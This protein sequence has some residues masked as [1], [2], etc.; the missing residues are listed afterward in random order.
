[1]SSGNGPILVPIDFSEQSFIALSQSY[2]L[3]RLT[4]SP[5]R[6]LHVIDQDFFSSITEGLLS[7]Y[8]YGDTIKEDLQNRLDEIAVKIKQEQNIVAVTNLR[9]G[10]IYNEIIEE[11]KDSSASLI[12]MGTMGSSTLMKKFMGSNASRV[13]RE[14]ECPV[15]TIKGT[16][17]RKG[18]DN[19]LLPLDLT[20]ET[21]EKVSKVIELARLYKSHVHI[22]TILESDDEFILK[23]LERQMEQVKEFVEGED[24]PCSVAFSKSD[25]VAEG[26]NEYAKQL[27]A[28]LV[29]IMTQQEL[30]FSDLFL[31]PKA[32]EV[33]NLLDIPVLC[34]R[35]IK[36]KDLTEFVLS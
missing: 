1:M 19:I 15:I 2:N 17:H 5:I 35:P 18:C 9:T 11:S 26:I 29:V 27:N 31:G 14:A 4:N 20:K 33:I 25:N 7:Q 32:Q 36:R 8:N 22:V 28:D 30:N 34:I 3:A 12:V 23:K 6:L 10:K 13:I 24:I 16:E 21:K